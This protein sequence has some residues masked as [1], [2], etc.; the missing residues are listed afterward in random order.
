MKNKIGVVSRVLG[1]STKTIRYYESVGLVEVPQREGCSWHSRGQ[2]IY[3]E[4][5]MDR[6]RFIKEAR[7]L[8]FSISEIRQVLENY[9]NGPRCGCSARPYLKTLI[10]QKLMEV[11]A[12]I[13]DLTS[14]KLELLKLHERILSLEDKTPDELLSEDEP[15]VGDALF[16]RINPEN[17]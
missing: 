8:N 1:L 3:D 2:R 15:N 9:E 11:D 16:G 6:L 17:K 13:V 10:K 12:D 4:K 5:E 7:Q 14:L